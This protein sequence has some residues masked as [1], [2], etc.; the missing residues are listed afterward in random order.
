M[1]DIQATIYTTAALLSFFAIY[2]IG[3][4]AKTITSL[5]I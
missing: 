1:K 2:G 4:V 5:V 3:A